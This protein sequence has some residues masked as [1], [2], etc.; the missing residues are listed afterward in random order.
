MDRLASISELAAALKKGRLEKHLSQR[1]LSAK[2][3][4][5]QSHISKIEGAK[6]DLQASSLI[7]LARAMDLEIVLIPRALVPAVTGLTYS[8]PATVDR[9]RGSAEART[10][11]AL[12]KA[13]KEA[14]R[15]S[16]RLG[17]PPELTRFIT[18]AR[19]LERLRFAHSQI[20]QIQDALA[21]LKTASHVL[22]RQ[23]AG[24]MATRDLLVSDPVRRA[25]G[26]YAP[27]ADQLRTIR[28]MLVH[29]ASESA[30]RSMPAY[31]PS[32]G[33]DDA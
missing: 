21:R 20:E 17:S 29:G 16:R 10:S 2:A 12:E 8:A 24:K 27:V 22:K 18:A 15:F 3:G 25:L 19:D 9:A 31:R 26:Q 6:V 4:V 13:R 33:D 5:P 1:E 32:D 7:E 11:E 30:A 28:N 14:S 23:V